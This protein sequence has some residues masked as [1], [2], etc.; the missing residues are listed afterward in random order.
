M[1]DGVSRSPP[2]NSTLISSLMS[3]AEEEDLSVVASGVEEL[4]PASLQRFIREGVKDGN[5]NF[6]GSVLTSFQSEFVNE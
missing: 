4:P 1:I 3:Y 6:T 5:P 2:Q